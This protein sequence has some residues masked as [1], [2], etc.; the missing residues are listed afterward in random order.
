MQLFINNRFVDG[1]NGTKLPVID[2]RTGSTILE[3]DE[4]STEDVD[5]AVHAASDAFNTGSWPRTA[6]NVCFPLEMQVFH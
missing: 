6:A 4:G 2:P 5:R 1:N 3:V